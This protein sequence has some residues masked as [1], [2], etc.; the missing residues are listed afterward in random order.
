M[1]SILGFSWFIHQVF[2]ALGV[3]LGGY[4]RTMT[5]NYTLA[6]WLGA[7]LLGFGVVLTVLMKEQTVA[8]NSRTALQ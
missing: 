6:F 4:L 3:F 5:G 1:G 2:A 8:I 7:V